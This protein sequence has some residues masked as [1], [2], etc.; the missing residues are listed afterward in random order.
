MDV[1]VLTHGTRGDV[2]P[3][4]AL[5]LAL[6]SAGHTVRLGA[7]AGSAALAKPYGIPFVPLADGPNELY[8]HPAVRE[9]LET[10]YRGLRGKR[11]AMTV[12]RMYRNKMDAVLDDMADAARAGADVIVHDIVLPGRQLGE[13][14]G[15][16][17]V[18]A[19]LQP[20]WVPTRAFP[21]PM[22]DLPLPVT[23][24]RLTYLTTNI[25]YQILAGHTNR[26]RR[27]KLGL[28]RR[29]GYLDV[30][31]MPGGGSTPLLQAFSAHLLAPPPDDY[32][33]WVQTTGPWLLPAPPDWMP[34]TDLNDFLHSG[35][36]VVYVGFGSMAGS[37]P[38]RTARM[39]T[40]A[41]R[42]AGVRAVVGTGWGGIE[43]SKNDQDI[44]PVGD[45]PHDWLFEHVTAVVHHGGSGTTAAALAAGRPQVVCPFVLDQP[46]FA[47]RVHEL[48]AAPEP[49]PQRQ[50]N[51]TEL[52]RAI[53]MAVTDQSFSISA[54][55]LAE[56]IRDEEGIDRAVRLI[57]DV[58]RPT[59]SRRSLRRPPSRTRPG[60]P[61][62][63]RTPG[64]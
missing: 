37:D 29:G 53:E 24:N 10:N 64:P 14:L 60:T 8:G 55:R 6:T 54:K 19:C 50:L 39:I 23:W 58:A 56:W 25:W 13:W 2:Q 36:P 61:C 28:T 35:A 26:W 48:G 59:I 4:I 40:E 12:A 17:T 51:A 63:R 33:S 45:V 34:S 11:L 47:R 16:P 62:A 52:A 30:L 9:V 3:F 18:R 5:A 46:F 42:S 57:E 38:G 1:L 44:L 31:R 21:N 7:P 27:N 20:F 41:V 32:P 49:L 22:H 15:I 43:A